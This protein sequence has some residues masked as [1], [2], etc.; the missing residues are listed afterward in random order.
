MRSAEV[1]AKLHVFTLE[2]GD[3]L[4]EKNGYKDLDGLDA[5]VAY[6]VNKHHWL[7]K[8]IRSM[9]EDDLRVVL[10]DEFREAEKATKKRR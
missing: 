8:E 9:S 2:L 4:A 1:G 3:Y 10:T 5:I 6:L 7:P